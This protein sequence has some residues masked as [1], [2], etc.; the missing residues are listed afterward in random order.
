MSERIPPNSEEA[1][2]AVLGSMMLDPSRVIPI[3]LNQFQLVED[4]FYTGFHRELFVLITELFATPRAYVDLLTVTQLARDRG[5][6]ERC[7]GARYLETIIDETPTQAHAEYYL[8]IVRE[9][10]IRRRAIDVGMVVVEELRSS[11]ERADTLVMGVPQRFGELV[12]QVDQEKK[13]ADHLNDLRDE[14]SE[15]RTRREAGETGV[16]GGLAAPWPK[17]NE[18]LCGIRPGLMII[19]GRPSQGKTTLEGHIMV[20]LAAGGVPVGRV[21]MDMT[22]KRLLA[23]ALCMKAGVSLAK[24]NYGYATGANFESVDQWKEIIGNYPMYFLEKRTD[25]RA[26][27]SW[28]RAMVM[29]RGIKA[30]SIDYIQQI[31]TGIMRLDADE[32][33]RITYVSGTLKALAHELNI[34]ILAVSQLSRQSETADRA[35][36]LSDLRG[37]GTL[38]QD[39]QVVLFVF[40]DKDVARENNKRPTWVDCQKNQD[41]GCGAI[42]FWLHEKYFQFEEA[43]P[44]FGVPEG[45]KVKRKSHKGPPVAADAPDWARTSQEL[46][47]ETEA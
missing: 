36:K 28:A 3:A 21:T 13:N 17:V 31:R 32:N 40:Q 15:A 44:R 20:E 42:P 19:S 45:E 16:V 46:M 35:P 12:G 43:P 6:L 34:P 2:R 25:L 8:D 39:A 41:G 5:A 37:S 38:E 4:A 24:L 22:T 10:W 9:K 14:W 30:L 29:R 33:G 18:L 27:C 1:E 7:G 11:E 26:I 23:R 47:A